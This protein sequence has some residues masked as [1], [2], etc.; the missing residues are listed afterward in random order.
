MENIPP[1]LAKSYT[2]VDFF[3][4]MIFLCDHTIDMEEDLPIFYG[5]GDLFVKHLFA[6]IEYCKKND[7]LHEDVMMKFLS[8]SLKWYAQMWY[9]ILGK[10]MFSSFAMF[11]EEFCA[12][13]D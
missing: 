3:G 9:E 12:S 4:M 1:W 5:Y 6:V 8:M 2:S 10:G 11:L 13:W 7:F